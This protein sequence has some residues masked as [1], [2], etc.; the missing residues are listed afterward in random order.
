MFVCTNKNEEKTPMV[1]MKQKKVG[2][3]H[4]TAN[5]TIIVVLCFQILEV[6]DDK[7]CNKNS[8]T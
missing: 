8:S 2:R 6:I 4:C 5:K 3:W 1:S 7:Q